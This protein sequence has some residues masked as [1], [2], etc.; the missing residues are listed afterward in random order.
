MYI[1]EILK[2]INLEYL[3]II[4]RKLNLN[5]YAKVGG[6]PSISQREIL[7]LSIPMPELSIQNELVSQSN[8]IQKLVNQNNELIKLYSQKLENKIN[9]IW[10][11]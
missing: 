11:I 9:Q 7:S 1:K 10:G 6:Q 4:L 3:A 2:P 8:H 5:Q